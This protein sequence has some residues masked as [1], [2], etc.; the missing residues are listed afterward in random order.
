MLV[1]IIAATCV[2]AETVVVKPFQYLKSEVAKNERPYRFNKYETIISGGLAFLVGNIGFYTTDSDTLKLAY[3]GV[4]TVGIVTVGQGVYD[5]YRPN[6][7]QEM[8]N[9][10]MK[11]KISRS[12]MADGF[13]DILGQEERAKRLALLYGSTLLVAQYAANAYLSDTPQDIK[14]IY[15]FLGGVNV[16]VAGSSYF[17]RGKYEL[18]L[19]EKQQ[20]TWLP[21]LSPQGAGLVLSS[22]F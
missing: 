6:Q 19:D 1:L 5:Y 9:L 10:L 14:D 12:Q 22:T 8:L 18:Y 4:Q 21:T 15:L 13:I 11:D 16:I 3:G 7:D 2:Q 20:V 17:S